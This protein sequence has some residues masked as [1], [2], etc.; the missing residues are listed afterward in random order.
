MGLVGARQDR[1]GG[2]GAAEINGGGGRLMRGIWGVVDVDAGEE[3][4]ADEGAD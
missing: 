3:E 1:G 2:W 4:D